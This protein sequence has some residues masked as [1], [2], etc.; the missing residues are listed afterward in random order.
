M[1]FLMNKL[2]KIL[3][4]VSMLFLVATQA[5]AA[6]KKAEVTD[7]MDKAIVHFNKVGAEQAFKDFSDPNGG[8]IVGEIYVVAMDMEGKFVH[9]SINPKLNGKD[10]YGLKDADGKNITKDSID[11][12]KSAESLWI[13]YKWSN[14]ATKKIGQKESLIKKAN[15][16]VYFMVGYYVN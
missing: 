10:G 12:L 9:H 2:G 11:G 7:L 14:P 1:D 8:F 15:K 6:D 13:T 16:D 3:S 4:V 5:Q